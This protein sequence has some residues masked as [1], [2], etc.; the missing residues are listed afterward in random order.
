M[1]PAERSRRYRGRKRAGEMVVRVQLARE[2]IDALIDA[3]LLPAW[4]D[5]DREAV[6]AA[7]AR[8]VVLLARDA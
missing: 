8:A 4:S 1:T 7:L 3:G 6:E 2:D 5:D